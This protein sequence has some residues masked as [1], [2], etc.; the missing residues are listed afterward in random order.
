[1]DLGFRFFEIFFNTFSEIQPEF[2]KELKRKLDGNGC[3]VKSIHPFT[4]GF[5]TMMLFSCL[6]YTS[7]CV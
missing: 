1:M 2:A 7:R 3:E 4:S 6:L 5:E